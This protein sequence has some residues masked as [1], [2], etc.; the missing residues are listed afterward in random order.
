MPFCL[1]CLD[2]RVRSQ[3]NKVSP[4]IAVCFIFN[5]FFKN[6]V[7]L[8][9]INEQ[10]VHFANNN[11]TENG[12]NLMYALTWTRSRCHLYSSQHKHCF[13][14][15]WCLFSRPGL[16]WVTASK[17]TNP[18]T[19][20]VILVPFLKAVRCKSCWSVRL[21]KENTLSMYLFWKQFHDNH[22]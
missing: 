7:N 18:K 16:V 21:S 4:W 15:F 1:F 14:L 2:Q 20:V 17:A 22:F 13:S 5:D 6:K 10:I 12:L 3:K 8:F 11:I 9:L 19:R